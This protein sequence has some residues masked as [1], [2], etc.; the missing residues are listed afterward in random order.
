MR[1][2]NNLVDVTNYVMLETGQPLH[3]FDFDKIRGRRIIVRRARDGESL[4]TLDGAE[5]RLTGE[6][7]VI[8]DDA[9]AVAIAG[10]M[11]GMDCEVSPE[12]VNVLLESAH[13]DHLAVRRTARRLGLRSEAAARFE[14]GTDPDGCLFAAGRAAALMRELSGGTVLAGAVDVCPRPVAPRRIRLRPERVN[15]LLGT[16]LSSEAIAALLRRLGLDVAGAEAGAGW[17]EGGDH[18]LVTVPTRRPDIEGEA[19]LAEEVA[20]MYGYNRI[21]TTFP[22]SPVAPHPPGPERSLVESVREVCL[23]T[24][25]NEVVTFSFHSP[26][27]WDRL[28]LPPDDPRRLAIP[29]ANPLSEEQG[30][31]RTCLMP[32][33]LD[34]V[35]ANVRHRLADVAVFEVGRVYRPERLPLQDL[36]EERLSLGI[37]LA[38]DLAPATWQGAARPADFFALKGLVETVCDRLGLPGSE[39]AGGEVPAFHPGRAARLRLDGREVGILGEI[40]P[41]VQAV[42]ELPGRVYVAELDLTALLGLARPARIFRPLPRFPAVDRD[43]AFALPADVP[44]GRVEAIIRRNAGPLLADLRL[45]DVYQGAPVP[46]GWRSLAYALAYQAPDRTLTDDEVEAVHDGIRRALRDELGATLRS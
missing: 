34:V 29:L 25:L 37:V 39:Y 19:D 40:H 4:T 38:G 5:R 12:T 28:G 3:A 9:G 13:F 16:G 22:R 1:S 8:A 24:G 18:L 2:I 27:A 31:M 26:A 21:P 33:L 45:F 6:D 32:L 17:R 23:A 10:V 20:R 7:L 46:D 36:P 43:L 15:A 44:A 14:K 42:Y 35:A 11:G 30:V 41:A